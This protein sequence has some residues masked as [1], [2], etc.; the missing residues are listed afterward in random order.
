MKE[1][2]H[3][4]EVFQIDDSKGCYYEVT[5]KDQTGFVGVNLNPNATD[6]SPYTWYTEK[7][8]VRPDGLVA[9]SVNG[10]SIEANLNALC[11]RLVQAYQMAQAHTSFDPKPYCEALHDFAKKLD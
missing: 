2:K 4:G 7:S 6:S 1:Y 8:V 11:Q 9:G 5:Y 3:N 10:P